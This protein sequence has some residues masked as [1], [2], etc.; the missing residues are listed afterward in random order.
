MAFSKSSKIYVAGHNG[1]VGSAIVRK[2]KSLGYENLVLKSSKEL[3]LRNSEDV[4]SFFNKERPEFVFLAA[5]KVGGILANSNYKA[6]FIFDNLTIQNN[7]I[8][9][10]HLFK[11]EKLLFL[12]S[13]CIYPK[14]SSTNKRRV[15]INWT[16]GKNQRALCYS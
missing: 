6:D 5:A 2:L 1:M 8:K 14:R 4:T 7:V 11:V 16:F 12:G 13:S 3:D 15:P 9:N 10:A